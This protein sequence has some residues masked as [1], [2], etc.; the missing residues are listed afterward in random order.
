[1]KLNYYQLKEIA[2]KEELEDLYK[3]HTINWITEYYNVKNCGLVRKLFRE[4]GIK[5]HR[6]GSHNGIKATDYD[7]LMK[8]IPKLSKDIEYE[9][10]HPWGW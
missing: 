7:E 6:C 3:D 10:R 5:I 4:F 1:M 9:E 2:S 8:K